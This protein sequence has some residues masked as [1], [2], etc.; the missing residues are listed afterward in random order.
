MKGERNDRLNEENG[1]TNGVKH[2]KKLIYDTNESMEC[3]KGDGISK[4][5][6][7]YEKKIPRVTFVT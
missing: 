1:E 4:F 2:A 7:K 3:R 5:V 6:E